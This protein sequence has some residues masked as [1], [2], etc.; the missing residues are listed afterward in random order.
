MLK[1]ILAFTLISIGL[2]SLSAQ[3]FNADIN[4][5]P[6]SFSKNIAVPD[7]LKILAV[8]V[9]FQ[10]DKDEATF[11]NGKFGSIYSKDYGSDILDPLPHNKAYFE[12]HL[13]FVKNYYQK[14]SGG[15]LPVV[16][17][18]LPD[19]FSVSK[20]MRNYSP[21]NNSSDFTNVADF[22]KEVWNLADAKYPAFNFGGYNVF[23]IFHAGV[24]RDVTLPGSLGTEKDI[25][26]IYLGLNALKEIYG[27]NFNGFPV[28]NNNFSIS[29]SII[30]PET[31][32]R[33]LSSVGGEI[34]FE[35][36]INGLLAASVASYL[37]LPDLF[38]TE[39][40]LSA[41]GRFGL[42]DGQSIFA[43][44]GL[45]PPEMSAW[46][47]MYLGWLTPLTLSP[48]DYK[49]NLTTNQAAALSD[50][51]AVKIPISST[52]YYLVQ[53]RNRDAHA[54]GAIIKY[55]S[56]GTSF[57]RT[58]YKDTTGFYSYDTD[59]LQG[60]VT[61][62][63]EFD[64]AVPGSGILIWHID[65]NII[66]Q[67]IADNK[68]NVDKEN[69][70]VDLEEADGI[71][72][73]GEKF[74]DIL[75]D[76][77]V[78]EGGPEDLWFQGND[79]K[80]YENKFSKDTRPKSITN[81]G[82]NSLI[83]ISNFSSIANKMSFNVVYGDSIVKPIF[84]NQLNLVTSNNSLTSITNGFA[85]LNDSSLV[86]LN[87]NGEQV[88]T[89][90]SFSN[91]KTAAYSENGSQ[92]IIGAIGSTLNV[93]VNDGNSVKV[94]Q[95]NV[96]E[97]ITAPPVVF[98]KSV[99]QYQ[100]L[101]GTISGKLLT[102]SSG[103][104]SVNPQLIETKSIASEPIFK[105]AADGDQFFSV[106]TAT[107]VIDK[108]EKEYNYA[109][110][111]DT[112]INKNLGLNESSLSNID[113][114]LTQD[115]AGNY[116]S[117]LR[118]GNGLVEVISNGINV[119]KFD[120]KLSDRSNTFALTDLKNDGSNYIVYT[121]GNKIEAKN[122]YGAS[123]D[124]FPFSDPLGIGFVGQPVAADFEGDNRSEIIAATSDG[125]IFA[126]DGGTGKVVDDFP[127]SVGKP[128][129][130]TPTIF[131]SNGKIALA[132]INNQNYFSA[133]TISSTPGRGFWDEANGNTL[134]SSF[135][136]SAKSDNQTTEFFPTNRAYNYP[137]PVYGGETQ[138]RYYVSENSKINIKIFDLAGDFV[139]ELNAAAA[140]GTDNETTW[141]VGNIQSGVYLARIEAVSESGKTEQNIIKIAI[142]K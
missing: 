107:K 3:S 141:N 139:A 36:S 14:V 68:I 8:M 99:N 81:S 109:L 127:V 79:S 130:A 15:K 129:A 9:N 86:I 16:Y 48:G 142:V 76:V 23:I 43:Y 128:L 112:H 83:T 101:L 51:V 25:P 20:T 82:A 13:E 67:N 35:I 5:F 65:E 91:F 41:I 102:Y 106:L 64:W 34:L 78:G 113:L 56:N 131:T 124:N 52:E 60:V 45:F 6:K 132:V 26:S 59:S 7:T 121:N 138:I 40:G 57:T 18:V 21:A 58:L 104:I 103:S 94:N 24:G 71:Q 98:V 134:N 44:N 114:S 125:R 85:L 115:K 77:F 108:N 137:N 42:M 30:I 72:D 29:N 70:G 100:I 39:T 17:A 37:G 50:T 84:S 47:K 2:S 89:F 87:L 116:L 93:Y 1:N 88:N 27:D 133:W 73:I 120:T 10:E 126:I 90:Q 54:D 19:T 28:S 46:E 12:A 122:I 92:Y 75:G 119:A 97:K 80:F 136:S 66:N 63:D 31:E 62:V 105:I 55:I 140:G 117:I 135:L 96:G 118:Y 11:G 123:A 33:E 22:S 32:S 74:Q 38:D 61:D 69:R 110:A 4:P 95:F 111:G 53:N 49:I